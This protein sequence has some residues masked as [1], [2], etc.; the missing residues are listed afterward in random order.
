MTGNGKGWLIY[1]KNDAERNH[2]F[3]KMLQEEARLRDVSLL[4]VFEEDLSYGVTENKLAVTHPH[5][6]MGD[7]SFAI[8]RAINPLLSKQLEQLGIVCFNRST[9]SEI[10]ND[11]A[12]TYQFVA[13][14]GIPML[15]TYFVSHG[16]FNG[17]SFGS[18]FP[19]V[20]KQSDGRGGKEVYLVH[21]EDEVLNKLSEA[22]TKRFV[23]QAF[24]D[25]PGK[26]IRVF[27]IG[28]RIIGAVLRESSSSFKANYTLGGTVRPYF[29]NEDEKELV[30]RISSSLN[31]DFIG[32]DFLLNKNGELLFNEIEDVVGCRSLYATSDVNA[33]ALY[34]DY[35]KKVLKTC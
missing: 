30:G 25:N 28:N 1:K 18:I 24:S 31:A 12:L 32:I 26:D 11:K 19:M 8:M 7:I 17:E 20:L 27:V 15:N 2:G 6:D 13:G 33:A 22:P 16:M 35:I 5:F 9:V 21:S 23:L 4:L 10:C 3:I 29:L 34:M 14:L